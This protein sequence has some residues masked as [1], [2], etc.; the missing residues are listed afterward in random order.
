MKAKIHFPP[1]FWGHIVGCQKK[2]KS[3]QFGPLS[4]KRQIVLTGKK[5]P[6]IK[7]RGQN[8]NIF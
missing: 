8:F 2:K 7:I 6:M 4:H 5:C 1:T 3:S